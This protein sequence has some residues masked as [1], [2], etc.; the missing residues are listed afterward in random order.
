[1]VALFS[2]VDTAYGQASGSD[3]PLLD[4]V[5]VAVPPQAERSKSTTFVEQANMRG[6]H[7][8]NMND[9]LFSMIP[10][11]ATARRSNLGFMGPGSGFIIRGL[12]R[13]RVAVFID[14]IPSQVNNHFHPLVDQYTPDLIERIEII[15]GPSPVRHGASAV[16]GVINIFTHSPSREGFSGYLS[17]VGGRFDTLEAQYRAGYGWGSGS[18]LFSGSYRDTDGHR[19]NSAFDANTLN[20]KLTHDLNPN[21]TA[22]LRAGATRADIENP[23]SASSP[24]LSQG[25]QDP[26]NFALTLD[27]KTETSNSFASFYWNEN[28]VESLRDGRGRPTGFL[29]FEEAEFGVRLKHDYIRS[30]GNT[31]TGGLD[32]VLYDDDRRVSANT[33]VKNSE[34]FVSPYVAFTQA[35]GDRILLDGGLRL[36]H[37]SQFGTNVSPEAGVVFFARPTLALRGYVGRGFRVPRVD[38]VHAVSNADLVN[39]DLEPEDFWNVEGG[40]NKRFAQAEFDVALWW[41]RGDNL[42]ERGAA[43]LRRNTGRFSQRG[44]EASLSV[45]LSDYLDLNLGL[46]FL[47]LETAQSAN[48]QIPRQTFDLGLDFHYD[49]WR[50]YLTSRYA[51]D[52]YGGEGQRAISNYY[53]ADLHLEYDF[54]RGFAGFMDIDNITDEEYQTFRDYPQVPRGY[55]LGLRKTFR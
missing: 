19:P 50:A 53:V 43:G 29:R 51:A 3:A 44:V 36:T 22:G 8:Q 35:M 11:V 24:S 9:V 4:P 30:P 21:W 32:W 20:F 14:G 34:N 16:G 27:R 23:G 38:E 26:T 48:E 17:T 45:A 41:M 31:L 54:G 37:S 52:L 1:M 55:F 6:Q 49:K 10:G 15:R 40:L 18:A 39:E 12:N 25:T 5:E 42:I 47:G 46:A 7:M 2:V 28:S 13:E 33:F